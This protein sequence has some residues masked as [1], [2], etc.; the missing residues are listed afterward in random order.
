MKKLVITKQHLDENNNYIG[1]DVS[2]WQGSIEIEARLGRIVF[3]GSLKATGYIAA[4]TGTGIKA[5]TGI[6]AGW[7]IEAGEGITAGTGITAGWGIT[8]KTLKSKLRI[9]AGLCHWRLPEKEET[10]IKCEE[11]LGGEICYGELVILET[12][13]ESEVKEMTVADV[14]KALGHSVKIVK[15]TK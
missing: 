11:L 13:K 8:C 7:G 2:D 1:P 9:F 12:A 15:E 10:L 3:K 4:F 5:G 6:E 14:E